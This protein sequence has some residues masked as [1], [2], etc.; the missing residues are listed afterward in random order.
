VRGVRGQPV[1]R[2]WIVL[3]MR[4]VLA[5]V[6]IYAA[7]TKLPAVD[8]FAEEIANY[9]LVPAVTV[10]WLAA[11]LPGVEMLCG[12][13]LLTNRFAR[14]SAVLLSALLAVFIV[15]LSQALLR[16]INLTCGCFGGAEVATWGTVVRDVVILAA[17]LAVAWASGLPADHGPIALTPTGAGDKT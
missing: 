15:G 3:A 13:L 4:V 17:A 6:F 5:G 12:V 14:A 10:P 9:R 1:T 11:A 2:K 8:A 16:G 7:I